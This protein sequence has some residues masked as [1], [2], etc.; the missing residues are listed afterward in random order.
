MYYLKD[1]LFSQT[2]ISIF[3]ENFKSKIF[4]CKQK[5]CSLVFVLEKWNTDTVRWLQG[6]QI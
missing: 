4:V 5:F 3:A 1:D 2:Y 6:L